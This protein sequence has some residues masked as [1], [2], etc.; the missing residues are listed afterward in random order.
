MSRL[1][2]FLILFL[3][4]IW[5]ASAQVTAINTPAGSVANGATITLTWSYTPQTNPLPGTLSVIDNTTK[6]TVVI[7]SSVNLASQSLSWTVNVPPGTYYLALNDGSGDKNSG[8]F[9]VFQAGG[10]A[11]TAAPSSS[12]ATPAPA[13]SG[14]APFAPSTSGPPAVKAPAPSAPSASGSPTAKTPAP[15]ASSGPQAPSGASP[16]A[17]PHSSSNNVGIYIGIA[18][19]GIVVG[20]IF[21]FVGYHAYKKYQ[22]S[23]FI[24]TPGNADH[25]VKN[26]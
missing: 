14:A 13:P 24:P 22:D 25:N 4:F 17:Q 7:S 2:H 6:N 21:S 26:K 11:P 12:P 23:K 18:V 9:S 20:V 8:T 3:A 15:A 5:S 1:I 19:S 10:A 16:P